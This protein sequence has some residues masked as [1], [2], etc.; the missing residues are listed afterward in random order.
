MNI[1]KLIK[2]FFAGLL[3]TAESK[4]NPEIGLKLSEEVDAI[5]EDHLDLAKTLDL[6]IDVRFDQLRKDLAIAREALRKIECLTNDTDLSPSEIDSI[7][8]IALMGWRES[9]TVI[10]T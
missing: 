6:L 5:L 8:D 2:S 4:D 3:A 1:I 7:H 10:K 9:Q